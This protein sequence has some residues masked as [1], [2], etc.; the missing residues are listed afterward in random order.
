MYEMKTRKLQKGQEQGGHIHDLLLQYASVS[1]TTR[2]S[3]PS[4]VMGKDPLLQFRLI[5]GCV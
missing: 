3:I 4:C 2:L 1:I 5:E